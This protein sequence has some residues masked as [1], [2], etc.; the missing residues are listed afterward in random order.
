MFLNNDNSVKSQAQAPR[1]SGDSLTKSIGNGHWEEASAFG[2]DAFT[3]VGCVIMGVP[4]RFDS[5]AQHALPRMVFLVLLQNHETWETQFSTTNRH[6]KPAK[7]LL[8]RGERGAVIRA[9]DP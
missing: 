5:S 3:A 4:F 8:S 6:C 7:A 1:V 2:M 9:A